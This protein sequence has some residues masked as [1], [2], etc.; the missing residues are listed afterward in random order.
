[1]VPFILSSCFAVSLMSIFL[2]NIE[3]M[4]LYGILAIFIFLFSIIMKHL[5]I[6]VGQERHMRPNVIKSSHSFFWIFGGLMA[7]AYARE[8][9]KH[10]VNDGSILE[11]IADLICKFFESE[12]SR[13]IAL[14]ALCCGFSAV[15]AFKISKSNSIGRRTKEI[16]RK[17]RFL[18][19]I[20]SASLLALLASLISS[21]AREVDIARFAIRHACAL[22]GL[23]IAI[24]SISAGIFSALQ[25]KDRHQLF[26]AK[27]LVFLCG[28]FGG[29]IL[30]TESSWHFIIC[31]IYGT[32]VLLSLM[33]AREHDVLNYLNAL[34]LIC[35]LILILITLLD[36][37][38]F[39]S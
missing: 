38:I 24:I 15:E 26:I 10:A 31:V 28:A 36:C 11:Q 19:S 16:A 29:L 17:E 7:F 35:F 27:L 39:H 13:V 5:D 1:M 18:I 8:W 3:E 22:I 37:S 30:Y 32:P 25:D 4:P 33:F 2:K 6:K 20:M 23:P 14:L 34:I 9:S 21:L 12:M